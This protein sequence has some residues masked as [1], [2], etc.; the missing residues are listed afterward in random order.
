MKAFC[1]ECQRMLQPGFTTIVTP[2]NY[3]CTADG[4]IKEI[5]KEVRPDWDDG[6]EF[7]G[8]WC[9]ECSDWY[10]EA[11]Y[12][13]SDDDIFLSE[14]D[15]DDDFRCINCGRLTDGIYCPECENII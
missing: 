15:E 14:N 7:Y 3:E 6:I 4:D 2:F 5:S 9:C 8:W 1:P 10:N 11:E 12:R 13:E